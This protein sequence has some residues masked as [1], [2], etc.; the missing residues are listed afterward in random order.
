MKEFNKRNILISMLGFVLSRA[1]L[2]TLNPIA[3]AYFTAVYTEKST[4]VYIFLSTLIGMITMM[5]MTDVIKYGL[6]MIIIMVINA[7]VENS[8][9]Q[10]SVLKLSLISGIVTTAMSFTKGMLYV[11]IK[12]YILMA[13]VEGIAVFAFTGVFYKGV[14]YILY[15][16]KGQLLNNEQMISIAIIASIFVYA[17][18]KFDYSRFSLVQTATYFI[19]IFFGYKYGSGAG[20]ITGATCGIIL[21][22]QSNSLNIVGIMC[23]LGIVAGM[24]REV[25]KIGTLIAYVSASLALSYLYENHLMQVNKLSALASSMVL[26]TLLPRSIIY[27]IDINNEENMKYEDDLFVKQNLQNITRTKLKEF[28]ESFKKLSRTFNSIADKK[29]SLSRHDINQIFDDISDK[30]CKHCVNCNKC[31]K[32]EFYDTYKAAFVM[33]NSAEQNGYVE[34]NDVPDYFTSKCI[35]LKEFVLETN[36]SLELANLNLTWHNRMAESR[37]A[38]AGQLCEVANIISDFS[39]DLYETVEVKESR[40]ENIKRRLKANHI[41]VK[42]ITILEK[43]NKRQEIYMIA[44]TESGRCITTKEAASI[45][46]NSFEKR[47]C[48]SEGTKN[49]IAKDYD[50]FIFVE[51]TN[52]NVLTGAARV[53]KTGEKVSGDNFSFIRLE[54][55]ELIMTLS[56]G[57]GTGVKACEESESVIEL[58]EQFMEAGFK[59]DSAIKLI[60]SILVLKSEEQSF[61]TIDMGIINLFT[62][63]CE[64]IKIG[65]STTFIKRKTQVETISST[66][67]PVGVFNQVDYEGISKKLHDG[68]F[69]IMVTDGVLDC[70]PDLDKDKYLE[71]VIMNIKSKNPQDIANRI[72]EKAIEQNNNTAMDDMTVIVVGLWKK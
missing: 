58:L 10:V 27:K 33:L 29:S 51:D 22:L 21:G 9:G 5:P 46:S 50:T 6:I 64:F 13:I 47:M 37:E 2:Y 15:S 57:M 65:A 60:N 28:S 8:K 68:D 32:D 45:I 14:T 3:I 40:E 38:I 30:L 11:D 53:T 41:E 55:G 42:K 61:S 25:G 7:L 48:P 63:I 72:L 66:T 67:L 19:I 17:V 1:M 23:I 24:F 62:G 34:L 69:V 18:P 31:W 70:I 43:R 35:N 4:R 20:A 39:L 59:E 36:K 56:D 54:S 52:Y 44:R 26:F 16:K 71:D 49:V 12:Y